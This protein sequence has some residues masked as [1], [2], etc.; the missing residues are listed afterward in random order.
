MIYWHKDQ[1]IANTAMCPHMG[2]QLDF[3][4]GYIR[5]PWHGLCAD[6]IDREGSFFWG[7]EKENVNS[8]VQVSQ[9]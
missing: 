9:T 6:P 3:C 7:G 4:E 8:E 1:L 5:C 2:A